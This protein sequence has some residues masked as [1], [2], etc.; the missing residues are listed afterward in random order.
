MAEER[1]R[2]EQIRAR[3]EKSSLE[4]SLEQQQQMVRQ[5]VARPIRAERVAEVAPAAPRAV[6]AGAPT[7]WLQDRVTLSL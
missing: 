7:P 5:R 1:D 4:S 3:R 6:K 2:I